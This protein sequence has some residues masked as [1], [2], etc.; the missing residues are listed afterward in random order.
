MH[1]IPVD[2]SRVAWGRTGMGTARSAN[3][4]IRFKRPIGRERR[5]P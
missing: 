2:K 4:V 1:K 5:K 3:G